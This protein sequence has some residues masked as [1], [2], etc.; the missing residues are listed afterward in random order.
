M[1]PRRPPKKRPAPGSR[2]PK[3][4]AV[5]AAKLANGA[6]RCQ[7]H[8]ARPVNGKLVQCGGA[9]DMGGAG[10]GTC[11][12]KHGSKTPVGPASP[13]FRTGAASKLLPA[14]PVGLQGYAEAA[15]GD[16]DLISLRRH[17]A[18]AEARTV[19]LVNQLQSGTTEN[20]AAKLRDVLAD[21]DHLTRKATP[22]RDRLL[23]AVERARAVTLAIDD[24]AAVWREI[25]K[26]QETI[27]RLAATERQRLEALHEYITAEGLD[28]LAAGFLDILR[29][30]ILPFPDGPR[31]LKEIAHEIAGL[32]RANQLRVFPPGD[33]T[34][35]RED[36]TD[37]DGIA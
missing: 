3:C 9:A 34:P 24:T 7:K 26:Q 11:C 28:T 27:R 23:E 4:D 31:M 6:A 13:H 16:D 20:M 2:C 21:L 25:R 37:D 22:D 10:D 33:P 5:H 8:R 1:A 35:P 14:L 18:L 30:R 12:P 32:L 29:R 17:L 19:D 15:V 36:P